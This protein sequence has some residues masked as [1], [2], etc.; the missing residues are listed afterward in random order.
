MCKNDQE[1]SDAMTQKHYLGFERQKERD[2]GMDYFLQV[3]FQ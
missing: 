2:T 3:G 1:L